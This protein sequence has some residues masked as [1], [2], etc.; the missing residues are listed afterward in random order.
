MLLFDP[1]VSLHRL[2]AARSLP[3]AD[4]PALLGEEAP[5]AEGCFSE[6]G[7]LVSCYQATLTWL[8]GGCVGSVNGS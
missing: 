1:L 5:V 2:W 3:W 4:V 8:R 7:A 6:K